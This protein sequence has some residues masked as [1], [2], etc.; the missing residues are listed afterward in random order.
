MTVHFEPYSPKA[1]LENNSQRQSQKESK[2]MEHHQILASDSS[3]ESCYE[4]DDDVV[5]S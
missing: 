2:Q 3:D 1:E 5:S 4:T